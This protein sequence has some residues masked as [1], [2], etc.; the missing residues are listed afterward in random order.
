M[1]TVNLTS[2]PT[3]Q[4][5]LDVKIENWINENEV[6][7]DCDELFEKW[8]GMKSTHNRWREEQ[9]SIIIRILESIGKENPTIVD[10]GCRAG[11]LSEFLFKAPNKLRIVGIDSNPFLLMVYRNHF[12]EYKDRFRLILGDFRNEGVI[13]EAGSFDA[14]ASL[15]AF[16]N[17]SRQSVL[18]VYRSL[19]QSLPKGGIFVNGDVV[20]FSDEWFEELDLSW[21]PKKEWIR[22]IDFWGATKA[23][24]GIAEEIDEMLALTSFK[25]IPEHGYTSSFYVNSLKWAGFEVADVV[26]QAGNRIV[27][28]GKKA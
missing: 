23:E 12:A 18:K 17:L 26:F 24:F 8:V 27:Y 15:T 22:T 16:H 10:L 7:V 6:K 25:D 19:Y 4:I 28:C 5:I 2:C 14:A 9:A 3:W 20:T 1:A 21:K 11:G 13:K